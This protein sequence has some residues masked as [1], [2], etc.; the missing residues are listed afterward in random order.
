MPLRACKPLFLVSAELLNGACYFIGVARFRAEGR[1]V[2]DD[3]L[4]FEMPVERSRDI[5]TP[6]D[7]EAVERQLAAWGGTVP[8]TCA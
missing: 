4:G 3:G 1:L 5:D 8:E 2:F 7:F 6:T